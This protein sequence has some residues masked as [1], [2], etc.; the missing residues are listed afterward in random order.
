[1]QSELLAYA[2][3]D[4]RYS[5]ASTTDFQMHLK[6]LRLGVFNMVSFLTGLRSVWLLSAHAYRMIRLL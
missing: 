5:G 1:M 6:L 4:R 3:Q 2:I